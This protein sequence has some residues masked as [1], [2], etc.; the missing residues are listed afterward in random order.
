MAKKID[1]NLILSYLDGTCSESE[2]ILVSEWEKQNENNR[3]EL[4]RIRKIWNSPPSP[5]PKP[6]VEYALKKVWRKIDS[7][8]E[9]EIQIKQVFWKPLENFLHSYILNTSV[10][11]VGTVIIFLFIFYFIFNVTTTQKINEIEI[12]KKGVEKIFFPDGST[13]MADAGSTIKFPESFDENSREISLSG[14][15]Y[16][17]IK[18]D[19]DKPFIVH[20][21]N[22][23]IT[24]LGTKFNIRTWEYVTVTVLEGKVSFNG[25]KQ[26][27]EDGSVTLTKGFMSSL[28]LNGIPTLPDSLNT[29]E[30]ITWINREKKFTGARLSEVLNQL[31]R[32]YDLQFI[33]PDKSYLSTRVTIYI[34]NKPI[35][36][37]LEV[38]SLVTKTNYTI[39]KNRVIFY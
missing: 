22:G 32:W 17:N 21:N 8:M 9:P 4:E 6:D 14:E 10:L 31:E 16:F 36:E 29:T 26:K 27:N 39:E 12:A 25:D 3:I 1:W 33:L 19:P 37:I 28:D 24:V 2:R 34:E 23:K 7:Q 18:S 11:K 38:I 20:A 30:N 13:A 15:A 35:D 5:M